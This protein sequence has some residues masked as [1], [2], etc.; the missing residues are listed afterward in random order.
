MNGN[1]SLGSVLDLG[2]GTGLLGFEIK[3]ICTTLIGVDLSDNMLCEAKFKNV[4]S[5]LHKAEITDYLAKS[6]LNFNYFM[7]TD[8]FIYVGDLSDVFRLIKSRNKRSGTLIFSTEHTIEH[9]FHLQ[10]TGRYSHSKTYIESLCEEFDYEISQYSLVDLRK[11]KDILL[12]GGLY[13]LDF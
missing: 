10:K 9:G 6:H 3:D 1:K 13:I 5:K 12:K 2:C 11:D 8:V 7:A 4:Y